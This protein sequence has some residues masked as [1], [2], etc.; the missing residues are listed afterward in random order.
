MWEKQFV[1]CIKR[2]TSD[3]PRFAEALDIKQQ[4]LPKRIYKYRRDC[5]NSRQNLETDTV[6]LSSPDSYNDPYDCWFTFSQYDLLGA[7]ERRLVDTLVS[8]NE[9]QIVVPAERIENAKRGQKP[10]KA[11]AGHIPDS[12][13][14]GGN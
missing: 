12:S 10:L 9:L 13:S 7:L 14:A 3:Q 5:S 4:H 6:W 11:I 8:Q 1:D 2:S